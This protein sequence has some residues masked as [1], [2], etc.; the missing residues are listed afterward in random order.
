MRIAPTDP[1]LT[2]PEVTRDELQLEYTQTAPSEESS[3]SSD[4]SNETKDGLL[5]LQDFLKKKRA[6]LLN[7]KLDRALA[8]YQRV[9][10]GLAEE[11]GQLFQR[12]VQ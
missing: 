12:Y 4:D 2:R 3:A 6:R 11:K 7:P 10:S 1:I 9:A 5:R 8:T